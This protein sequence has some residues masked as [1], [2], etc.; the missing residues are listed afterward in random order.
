MLLVLGKSQ[1]WKH[2]QND[3]VYFKIILTCYIW[4][5]CTHQGNSFLAK[6]WKL[7]RKN[8]GDLLAKYLLLFFSQF[9]SGQYSTNPAI[10]FVPSVGSI[11]PI[12]PA[13]SE[14]F[15]SQPFIRFY[16]PASVLCTSTGIQDL[17]HSFSQ[18]GPPVWWITYIYW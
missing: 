3:Q 4:T 10:W 6:R 5:I 18:Y 2:V 14:R 7:I 9:V 17:G 15:F 1:S 8:I 11:L 13:H 12:R 16:S